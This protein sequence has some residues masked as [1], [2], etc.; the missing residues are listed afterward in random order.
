MKLV[1]RKI[2]GVLSILPAALLRCHI[3]LAIFLWPPGMLVA[4]THLAILPQRNY[5]ALFWSI[6]GN[7]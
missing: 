2:S 7:R 3:L 1:D 4:D 6:G 5:A